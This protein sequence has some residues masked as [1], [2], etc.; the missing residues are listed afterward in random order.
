MDI[1]SRVKNAV[2]P[3]RILLPRPGID[4]EKWAVIACDQHTSNNEY[5]ENVSEIVGDSPSTYNLA[6]PE[7]RLRQNAS[8]ETEAQRIGNNMNDYLKQ[9][10]LVYR[11]E[12]P[13]FIYT[14]RT[15]EDGKV[16]HG[17]VFL[18]DLEQ[19]EFCGSTTL[20]RPSEETIE[21]RLPAR[22]TVRRHSPIELPHVMMLFDDPDNRVI[23]SLSRSKGK[24]LYST[25]LM[26]GGG[27]AQAYSVDAEEQVHLAL[28][29]LINK[30]KDPM[31]MAVGDGNH[32]LAA[33]KCHWNKVKPYFSNHPS[34]Y[35]MVE[36]VNIHDPALDFFPIHRV[37]N[38][39]NGLMKSLSVIDSLQGSALSLHNV[40]SQQEMENHITE[41]SSSQSLG[42]S[43]VEKGIQKFGVAT[44]SPGIKSTAVGSLH[45]LL[46][47]LDRSINIDY[48]H[49][50][51]IV[52]RESAKENAVG[53]YVPVI[54][55]EKLFYAISEDTVCMKAFSL[56]SSNQKNYYIAARPIQEIAGIE[57]VP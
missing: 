48:V 23:Q 52:L 46:D 1:L 31:L 37:V 7:I 43:Y 24:L 12:K 53:F 6:L 54:N 3:A 51:F 44:F 10:L 56:G 26:L 29:S 47:S 15:L 17:L 13:G 22:E 11:Q 14:K 18:L 49:D 8:P 57:Y 41:N 20:F 19:Y 45:A 32:S 21:D 38:S 34:R 27:H 33:A 39:S 42:I 40:I 55:K 9:G 16:R 36:A 25:D 28:A 2:L 5:W 30:T 4:L 35:A 50:S